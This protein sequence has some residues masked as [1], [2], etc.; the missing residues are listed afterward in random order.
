[1]A[2]TIIKKLKQMAS[3]VALDEPAEG[4]DA[5]GEKLAW[6]AVDALLLGPN[7][8]QWADYMKMFDPTPQ[9]LL[10]L[11][12]KDD[13]KDDKVVRRACAYI[14]SN[15]ICGTGTGTITHRLVD[16]TIDVGL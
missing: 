12:L 11:T 5:L 3:R 9:E 10:R 16:E 7:S 6:M 15:A 2:G 1:M 4:E 13:R 14:V 8:Q